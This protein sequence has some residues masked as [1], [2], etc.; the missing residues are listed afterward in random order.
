MNVPDNDVE[1]IRK[2]HKRKISARQGE[3]LAPNLAL[4]G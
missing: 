2:E 3:E 1:N 4:L